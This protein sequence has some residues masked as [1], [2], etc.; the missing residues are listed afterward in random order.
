MSIWA[1]RGLCGWDLRKQTIAT[2]GFYIVRTNFELRGSVIFFS[3]SLFNMT[4]SFTV[5]G[6]VPHRTYCRLC[7]C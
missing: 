5:L 2:A 7:G 4:E 3:L 1:T 6:V